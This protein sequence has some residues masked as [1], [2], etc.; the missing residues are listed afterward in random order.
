MSAPCKRRNPRPCCGDAQGP[1]S[2]VGRGTLG[3]A[4]SRVPPVG[5]NA[6]LPPPRLDAAR[7][8][9]T[10]QERCDGYSG[11]NDVNK[12]FNFT[13]GNNIVYHTPEH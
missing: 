12:R 10:H 7:W 9:R 13:K 6:E 1:P 3:A 5:T 2:A 8:R 11:A 4:G